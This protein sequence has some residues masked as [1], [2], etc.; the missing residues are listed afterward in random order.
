MKIILVILLGVLGLLP[1]I[2]NESLMLTTLGSTG[3]ILISLNLIVT[4]LLRL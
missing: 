1:I 3:S 4:K 2:T